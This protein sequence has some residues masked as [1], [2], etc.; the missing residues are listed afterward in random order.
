MNTLVILNTCQH[1]LDPNPEYRPRPVEATIVRAPT[2][3][4]DDPCRTLCRE[5]QRGF[6]LT[7]FYFL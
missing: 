2:A 5:N 1:P 6:L 4:S 3:R 7:E